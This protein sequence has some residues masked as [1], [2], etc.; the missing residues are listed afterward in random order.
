M[1][2]NKNLVIYRGKIVDKNGISKQDSGKGDGSGN[3]AVS[4]PVLTA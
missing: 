3:G 2:K 4:Q 1:K